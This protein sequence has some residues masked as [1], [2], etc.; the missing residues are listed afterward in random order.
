MK[1]LVKILV[2]AVVT[3]VVLLFAGVWYL[4]R[5]I[6]SP[7]THAQVERELSKALKLPLK[8]KS[9][10]LSLT[11]GLKAEGVTIPDSAGN[12][13]AV[14]SFTAKHRF[15]SLIKRKLIFEEINVD[16]PKFVMVQRPDGKWKLPDLPPELQAELD[17]KKKAK[18]DKPK[19][20]KPENAPPPKP[21]EKKESDLLIES[22][23]I[24]DG[25]IEMIDKDGK[26]FASA[27]GLRIKLG[28]VNDEKLEG[29]VAINRIVLHGY[30]AIADFSA[31]ISNT[32]EKGLIV[33]KFKAK[34]GGGTAEGGYSRKEGKPKSTYSGTI[35][36]ENVDIT[37]AALDGGAPPQNL[38]GI[39]S[40]SAFVRGTNDDL[41]EISGDA[42]LHF[43]NGTCREI[44]MVKE[45]GEMLQIDDAAGFS[46][47]SASAVV[48]IWHGKLDIKSLDISAPPLALSATGTG[49][50]EGKLMLAAKLIAG[51]DFVAK[52]PALAPQFSPP[53][54][55]GKQFVAF[56][57]DGSF[58]KPKNNFKER[59]TGTKSKNTQTAIL[60]GTALDAAIKPPKKEGEP[61]PEKVEKEEQ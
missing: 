3:V 6:E 27:Q 32:P 57:V 33:P 29:H 18:S 15:S 46:I 43:A 56:D 10:T 9:L 61:E 24:T 22:I 60:I 38:M 51:A 42:T 58:T 25:S 11:G 28:D 39:F 21:K 44:E 53:D 19:T 34:V 37:R 55:N 50:I 36:I 12:F 17:A 14:P 41:D 48:K 30:L 59:I 52:H 23:K 8:F 47:P 13:F 7:E 26:P 5:W 40:G 1:R 4:N 2:I 45:I 54:A 31:G 35:K 49:K 20:P 16:A